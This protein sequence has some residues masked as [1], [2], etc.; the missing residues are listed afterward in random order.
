MVITVLVPLFLLP[1]PSLYSPLPTTSTPHY[2]Y[3]HYIYSPFVYIVETT[4]LAKRRYVG[5]N[6]WLRTSLVLASTCIYTS[7]INN[8][9]RGFSLQPCLPEESPQPISECSGPLRCVQ[10]LQWVAGNVE[11]KA[12]KRLQWLSQ[13]TNQ[14][15]VTPGVCACVCVHVCVCVCVWMCV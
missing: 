4:K 11:D 7:H 5:T 1:M 2:I 15:T 9:C 6:L 3:S 13:R 14:D 8:D 12:G 10:R